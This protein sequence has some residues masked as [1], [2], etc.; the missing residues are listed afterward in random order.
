MSQR[1]LKNIFI[2]G[3]MVSV[4]TTSKAAQTE[5]TTVARVW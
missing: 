3:R 4:S 5:S 1:E 2:R